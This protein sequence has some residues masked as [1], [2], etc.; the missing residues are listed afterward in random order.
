MIKAGEHYVIGADFGSDSVRVVVLDASDGRVAGSHVVY[1]PRWKEGLYCNPKANQFRQ[2]P[3]DYVESLTNAVVNALKETGDKTIAEKVRAICVDT[4]GSTPA[5][6]DEKG[7]PLALKPEFAEEPDAMFVLWKDHTAVA[8]ADEINALCKSWGGTD[9][10]KYMGGVYSS[11]W[12]WAKLLHLFRTNS[13][14]KAAAKSA[15]E[16]CDWITSLITGTD[17]PEKIKRSRCAAGHKIMWHAEWGGY[18]PHEFLDKLD[19]K[20]SE[21]RDSLGNETWTTDVPCGKLTSEWAE[22]FGLSTET[23]VCVGAYDAHI[24]AVGGDAA[25][26]V[27]VKSI[28]TSTCDVIIGEKP[29]NGEKEQLIDGIC[30]QVDGS[31]IANYIGYEAGQSAY[32]DYYAWLRNLLMWPLKN[33]EV[34]AKAGVETGS[35]IDVEA[36][37]KNLIRVL[38]ME[39]EKIEICGEN[40]EK[41]LVA[42]DWVNGRRTPYANQKLT[43][44]I[45]GINLGTDGPAMMRAL[46]EATAFGARAI[47]EAFEKGGIKI[48]KIMAIGGVARK[49]KLGMQI[50]ADVTNREIA[51][52]AGDQSCA[53]GAAVFAATAAGLYPD[54][55]TAQKALS[56]GVDRV[57]KPDPKA[58]AIYDKYYER[59]KKLGSFCEEVIK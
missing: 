12:F 44:A 33:L 25:P 13:K 27:L 28:G 15:V 5:L 19:P 4:T 22:K 42:T 51:V 34:F 7:I 50:L 31:V 59:Y 30:G 49:S 40:P 2:H 9:F 46:Y 23:I 43:A 20:L 56:A 47:I 52:T 38:E 55:F 16:H 37:E 21:I 45:S 53:I 10:T 8:E 54:I 36:V 57:H 26:G 58:A 35:Q 29:A 24:G 41:Y 48:E 32:G 1:Y 6:T 39:A 17:S 18:P 11:E 14:V 3:L